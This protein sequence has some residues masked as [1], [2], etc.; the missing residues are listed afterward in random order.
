[1]VDVY[2]LDSFGFQSNV[3]N[4]NSNVL[5]ATINHP[6]R[7]MVLTA[8]PVFTRLRFADAIFRR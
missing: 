7:Q 6:L 4:P 5:P 1:M 2:Q 8:P 3:I